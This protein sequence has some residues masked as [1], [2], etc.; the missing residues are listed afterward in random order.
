MTQPAKHRNG[1]NQLYNFVV[2]VSVE[3]HRVVRA[4]DPVGAERRAIE[5]A[6][7]RYGSQGFNIRAV[8]TER[9]DP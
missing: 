3:H 9:L 6:K 8:E 1:K 4:V 7:Q 2:T 5:Q